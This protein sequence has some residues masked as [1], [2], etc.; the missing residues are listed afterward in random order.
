MVDRTSDALES[1]TPGDSRPPAPVPRRLIV[2][3]DGTW[4][5]REHTTNVWR[6]KMMLRHNADQLIYYDEGVGTL[7]GEAF[8]GG[9]FA[10]G[11]SAKVLNAY[12]WL[13]EHYEDERESE[14]GVA[15]QL[16]VFGFSRGAFSARS[17]VG[18]LS[19]S[20][21]IHRDAAT[22][23]VDAF[24]VSRVNG[25]HD[26][27]ELSVNFRRTHSRSI[28]VHFLGVWDTVGALGIP[29][30]KGLP[31]LSAPLQE[32][33][34]WHKVK[35]LPSNVRHARHALAIDEKRE[36]FQPTLWP[37]AERTQ[38]MEQRWFCGAHANVGGGYENDA[39]FRRPLQ[40]LHSEAERCGLRF[41][42]RVGGLGDYFYGSPIRDSLDESLYGGYYLIQGLKA[43][44]RAIDLR[45]PHMRQS[46]DYTVLER[47]LWRPDYVSAPIETCIGTKPSRRA[48]HWLI[49]DAEILTAVPHLCAKP[50][51]GFAVN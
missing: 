49:N 37:S 14:R 41:R 30:V 4:N 2:L 7:K 8:A 38:S 5:R 20:G 44:H 51:R 34:A 11:L 29:R 40:W 17:L 46:L 43:F 19:I 42:K 32:Q 18:I 28:G 16:F 24:D 45:D 35:N 13:M 25:V 1:E 47:W 33:N 12:L 26:K 3:F 6:T 39:L 9:A 21:L 36:T 15:D 48:S 23:I 31:R 27:H 10:S 50:E 22:R